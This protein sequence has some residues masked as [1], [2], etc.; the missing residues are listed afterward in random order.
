M[1]K[2]IRQ[3][4]GYRPTLEILENRIALAIT[5][6]NL[7]Q[8]IEQGP[9]PAHFPGGVLGIEG[10]PV[11]G[12]IQAVLAH[13]TN[14]DIIY[15]GSVGGGVWRTGNATWEFDELD[16]DGDGLFD[17]DDLDERVHWIPLTDDLPSLS[18]SD[19]EFDPG[20][21]TFNSV[22]AATG[23]FSS[24][25]KKGIGQ[26]VI[27]LQS[28]NNGESWTSQVLGFDTLGN[29]NMRAVVPTNTTDSSTGQQ[30]IFAA[31]AGLGGGLFRSPDSGTTWTRTLVGSTFFIG[32]VTDLVADLNDPNIYYAGVVDTTLSTNTGVWRSNDA[33]ATWTQINS[34]IADT[35]DFKRGATNRIVLH[36][37]QASGHA[38]YAAFIQNVP[39]KSNPVAAELRGLFSSLNRG[40]TWVPRPVPTS[41]E[42][43]IT[44]GLHPGGQG[45]THFSL[46]SDPVTPNILFVGG[47]RQPHPTLNEAGCAIHRAR[48]FRGDLNQTDNVWE[49][50]VC[51]G[52]ND[53]AP[54]PDSRGA[55]IDADGHLLQV[56]DGGIFRLSDPNNVSTRR[57]VSL[58]GDL[59][60]TE[61]HSVAYDPLNN[62]LIGGSQDNG[63]LE[64][65]LTADNNQ[66]DDGDGQ[67]DELDERVRWDAVLPGDGNTQAVGVEG[68]QVYRYSLGNN[69]NLVTRRRFDEF[70]EQ[71]GGTPVLFLN[72]GFKDR[73]FTA[74]DTIP[75][76]VNAVNPQRLMVGY[77]HLYESNTRGTWVQIIDRFKQQELVRAIAYGGR[78]P[79][80]L[81]PS[82]PRS[83][84]A[85]GPTHRVARIRHRHRPRPN[86]L[87]D[88]LC[89]GLRR[90][91]L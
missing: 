54:H 71:Q 1:K 19:L 11:T 49:Q 27:R 56:D 44:N 85:D 36:L 35:T 87:A 28:T 14:S 58:N 74:F 88:S 34:G 15:V 17:A 25:G 6:L 51:V 57:W 91:R 41:T 12:A 60:I 68:D 70:G 75:L 22:W 31:I 18:I 9:G 52:A 10:S 21:T 5:P 20:D 2:R 4:P 33:G 86:E 46:T 69:F 29:K 48:L 65:P 40:N 84:R 53:T 55:I 59:R 79:S 23:N 63:S 64:Q 61:F 32:E 72:L 42:N 38:L 81:D 8:W 80:S 83:E 77:K 50:I 3:R 26:G 43:L 90:Q 16:N 82:Q 62:V 73:F 7:P 37:S 78:E 76:V 13:P 66:D 24:G 89:D 39:T 47:D 67:F 30:V 45:D